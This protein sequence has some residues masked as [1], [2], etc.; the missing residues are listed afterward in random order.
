MCVFETPPRCD[1]HLAS[2]VSV[3][4]GLSQPRIAWLAWLSWLAAHQGW[5]EPR[6]LATSDQAGGLPAH[7]GLETEWSTWIRNIWVRSRNCSC[8]VTWFCYQLVAKPGNKAAR[9]PWPH[10]YIIVPGSMDSWEWWLLLR[11]FT[12]LFNSLSPGQQ[13]FQNRFQVMTYLRKYRWYSFKL[14]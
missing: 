10:P 7:Q 2:C 13:E 6:S 3:R 1:Y 11:A 5:L 12:L 14:S 4:P 9:V 8:L